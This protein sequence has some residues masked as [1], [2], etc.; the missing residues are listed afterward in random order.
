V[1]TWRD[2]DAFLHAKG[3][4]I[5][6]PT[7]CQTDGG[8]FPNCGHVKGSNHY[9]GLARDYGDA[10]SDCRAVVAALEPYAASG[11]LIELFYAPTNT[12]W[13]NG[14]RLSASAVGGHLDHAHV[15]IGANASLPGAS[16]PNVADISS[17][18]GSFDAAAYA[19]SGRQAI[20]VKATEGVGYIN[21]HYAAWRDAAHEHGLVTGEYHYMGD[22]VHGVLHP[23][24]DEA[25]YFLGVV[26]PWSPG[27][28]AVCD[29]ES[30]QHGAYL[31]GM[32][33]QQA[34]DWT[35]VF[36]D[37]CAAEG[38]WPGMGYSMSGA[39][40]IQRLRAPYLRWYAAY[41]GPVPGDRALHQF[42][43]SAPVPGVGRCDDSYCF[44]DL[45]AITH[46]DAPPPPPP[47]WKVLVTGEGPVVYR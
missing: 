40:V 17:A 22:S 11:V 27:R 47:P 1:S 31:Y 38:G 15:A 43:S 21:P 36:L 28:L 13:K 4:R 24:V 2:I 39:G 46:V 18:Q 6:A 41:P 12:W 10:N 33:A 8:P 26:G 34:A 20:I 3:V 25:H 19:A 37:T 30:P 14:A 9:I 42:S 16:M 35:G 45:R 44:V 23:A 5:G 32:S 7:S 29:V